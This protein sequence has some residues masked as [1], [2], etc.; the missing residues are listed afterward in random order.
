MNNLIIDI[1][2]TILNGTRE[3]NH[4]STFIKYLEKTNK[5]YLLATNS[6]QSPDVQVQRLRQIGLSLPPDK[7]YSPI[8]SINQMIA[9]EKVSNVMV[10]G[11]KDEIAQVKANHTCESPELILLLDFEKSNF[12][13]KDLQAIIDHHENGADIFSASGS[14]Y[15]LKD[16]KKQID[17]GAFVHLFESITKCKIEILG[18][19]SLHYFLNAKAVLNENSSSITVI[20]DDWQTDILG[21]KQAG[22]QSILIKSGKYCQGDEHK[23]NPDSVIE[24]FLAILP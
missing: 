19:P 24:D 12:S 10:M 4:A 14:S 7:I 3:L 23:A 16:G 1:D 2:G 21:A 22:F 11:S 20:G 9:K 13:Y 6:I 17:T 5:R 15:Y 18:K 8:D